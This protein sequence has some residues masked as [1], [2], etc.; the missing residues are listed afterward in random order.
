MF[1]RTVRNSFSGSDD[2]AVLKL[3]NEKMKPLWTSQPGFHSISRYRVVEGPHKDQMMVV[4]RF[5]NKE[6]HDK[7]MKAVG[8]KREA[9]LK[10]IHAAGVKMEETML[11]EEATD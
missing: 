7:A 8:E 9:I 2:T 11:L 4:T 6:A 10:E 1:V 5:E 3:F